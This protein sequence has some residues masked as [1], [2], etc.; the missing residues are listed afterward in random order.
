LGREVFGVGFSGFGG[1]Q[2]PMA[3]SIAT[4]TT[5]DSCRSV[6]FA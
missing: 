4:V 6:N 2:I 5:T 3:S 1:K